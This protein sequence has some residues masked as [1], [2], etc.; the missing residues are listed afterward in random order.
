MGSVCPTDVNHHEQTIISF[1]IVSNGARP[2]TFHTCSKNLDLQTYL[3]FEKLLAMSKA[4]K[5]HVQ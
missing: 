5:A 2:L 3:V 1:L 4:I